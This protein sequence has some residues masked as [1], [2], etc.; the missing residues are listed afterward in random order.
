[1]SEHRLAERIALVTGASRGIGAAVAV[2]FAAEGAHVVLVARTVGGLEDTDD[3]I[4]AAGGKATLISLDLTDFERVDAL[5]PSLLKR[6]GRLDIFVGAAGI[7]GTLSPVGHITP[8]VW[9]AVIDT[10]LTANW[11]LVRTL[12]PLLK[13]S[14]AGRAIFVTADVARAPKAFWGAY[15]AAKAGLE[16]FARSW[17]A[18]SEKSSLRVNL[19]DPG[20]VATALRARAYPGE[21]TATLRRP[22]D[23]TAAFVDLACAEH[24]G[25]GQV[26]TSE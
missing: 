9:R 2:R 20:P 25:N 5:G 7:L 16:A 12:E 3:A 10:N 17:A 18:E 1:M 13:R 11:R 4:K 6:F 19:I 26:L 14:D 8:E 24:T 21:D 23:V 22:E 15:G